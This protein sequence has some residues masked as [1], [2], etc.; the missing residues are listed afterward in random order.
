MHPQV[1]SPGRIVHFHF[2]D[3]RTKARKMRPAIVVVAWGT[4][5]DACCN[6]QVFADPNDALP[7]F[8]SS[9]YQTSVPPAKTVDGVEDV[10]G[11]EH[12]GTCWSW[13]PRV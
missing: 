3:Q 9:L 13:P 4:T 10:S 2:T 12:A 7:L 6:L 11:G 8:P 1:P 5:P